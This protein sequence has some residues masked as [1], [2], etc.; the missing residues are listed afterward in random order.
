MYWL[1]TNT[2]TVIETKLKNAQGISIVYL[3]DDP[4]C[5]KV[6]DFWKGVGCSKSVFRQHEIKSPSP[7]VSNYPQVNTQPKLSVLASSLPQTCEYSSRFH[8]KEILKY[9]RVNNLKLLL[10][11]KMAD[12]RRK[13][14]RTRGRFQRMPSKRFIRDLSGWIL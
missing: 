4:N 5:C 12:R 14:Q 9:L 6:F 11:L 10:E 13:C 7:A 8:F 2:C 1:P 3:Q